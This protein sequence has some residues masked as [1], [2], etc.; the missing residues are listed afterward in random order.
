MGKRKIFEGNEREIAYRIAEERDVFIGGTHPP[1]TRIYSIEPD[2]KRVEC[3]LDLLVIGSARV[4]LAS[5]KL[6]LVTVEVL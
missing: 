2:C 5:R 1:L 4:P 3:V 6:F